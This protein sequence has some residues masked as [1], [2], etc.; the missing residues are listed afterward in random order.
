MKKNAHLLVILISLLASSYVFLFWM[1]ARLGDKTPIL[2]EL[3]QKQTA[4]QPEVEVLSQDLLTYIEGEREKSKEKIAKE[5]FE[6]EL[7][8]KLE[9]FQKDYMKSSEDLLDDRFATFDKDFEETELSVDVPEGLKDI[10]EFW[11]HI[12]GVYDRQQVV[13]YHKQDVSLV[14]SVLDFSELAQNSK[15]S[16]ESTR[17]QI[18]DMEVNRIRQTLAKVADVYSRR[19]GYND[20]SP[21]ERRVY[22]MLGERVAHLSLDPKDLKSSLSYRFGFAHRMKRSMTLSTQYMPTIQKVMREK[23]LPE[24]VTA[25]PFVESAFNPKAYSHAGAAGIWQFIEGTGKQYLKIDDVVDERFDPIMATYAAA[26]H[27]SREYKMLK[28]WP[29]TINAYNAGPGRLLKAIE[30]LQTRDIS[31]IVKQFRGSGYGFDSR[32]YFAEIVAA[33]EVYTNRHKY[34]GEDIRKL[35]PLS[36]EYVVMPTDTNLQDLVKVS[37]VDINHLVNLNPAI[38]DEVFSGEKPFPKGYFLRV[39][40]DHKEDLLL[41]AQEMYMNDQYKT[42]HVVKRYESLD[43]I[44]SKYGVA[45]DDLLETNNLLPG[46]KL[47]KGEILRLPYDFIKTQVT[48]MKKDNDQ[49]FEEEFEKKLKLME[50]REDEES[51]DHFE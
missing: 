23:G 27:L 25:I 28:S 47:K 10:V 48:M 21:D 30:K 1:P 45:V 20:L 3:D 16:Y 39:P 41:A 17:N 36:F 2:V 11:V 15:G 32:N 24:L 46:Q 40:K 35:S 31:T 43:R 44:A 33:Y 14:F 38:K 4:D 50:E 13:F 18:I 51:A 42:Y 7:L 34:F 37:Q 5:G 49:A 6:K 9:E 22:D 19:Q 12:F 8:D 29:L 26:A